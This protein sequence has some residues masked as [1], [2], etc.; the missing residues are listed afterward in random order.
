M[1]NGADPRT[2]Y[3]DL[4]KPIVNDE[5]GED[6]WGDKLNRNFDILDT[7]AQAMGADLDTIFEQALGDA[8][9]DGVLY[10]RKDLMWQEVPGLA[11]PD[12][13]DVQN[14]PSDYPPE[15]HRH[16]IAEIDQLPETLDTKLEDAPADGKT[17]GRKN[18]AWEPAAG[19][20]QIADDAPTGA[21][22]NT[23]WWDSNN[24]QLYIFFDDGDTQQWVQVV[25]AK[26][27]QGEVGPEGP[28]G[29]EGAAST[30]PGPVGPEGPE[31]PQ[32]ESG[33]VGPA[34]GI[35]EAPNDGKT[36]GRKSL[37]WAEVVAGG[38]GA[39]IAV[40]DTP[41]ASPQ[42][43][44]LWWES[45]TGALFLYFND[46]NTSQWVQVNGGGGSPQTGGNYAIRLNPNTITEN[47]I[48]PAGYNG[49]S[50]GP[51]TV[52]SGVTVSVADG[53]TWAVV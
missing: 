6:L 5:A 18:L 36:Y 14:K 10:G 52:A 16:Q 48:I 25:G 26:G 28:V 51:I 32:G 27:E 2:P 33:P 31:G 40:G 23:F 53:S 46:G 13:D 20:A 22:A 29:P 45:D 37:A 42:A 49:M 8:P 7:N 39:S 44:A 43:N 41:P 9:A 21:D 3:L 15:P 24:G 19:A 1:S 17:Y 12:W 4:T 47:A 11:A 35:A 30:V 50:A 34:G 38:G